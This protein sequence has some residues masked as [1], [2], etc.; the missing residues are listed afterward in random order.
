MAGSSYTVNETLLRQPEAVVY[1]AVNDADGKRVLLKTLSS[2]HGPKRRLATEARARD[3]VAAG[4]DGDSAADRARDARRHAGAGMRRLRRASAHADSSARPIEVDALS[5]D[6]RHASSRPSLRC[7]V[8]GLVHKDLKP[9][10]ILRPS[11]DRRGQADRARPGSRLPR[12][13]TAVQP[14][15]LIEGSLPYLSPEQTGQHG[16]GRRQSQRPVFA[17]R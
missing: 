5:R 1:R 11:G 4:I 3:G 6:C 16:A 10:N 12:E 17:R 9:E 2:R 15:L 13:L 14:P 7:T 8:R